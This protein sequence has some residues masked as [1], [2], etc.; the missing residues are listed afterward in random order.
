MMLG[1]VADDGMT[2]KDFLYKLCGKRKKSEQKRNLELMAEKHS[3]CSQE[4]DE[5]INETLREL[6]EDEAH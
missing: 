5:I 6:K 1:S 4:L 3:Q 2:I